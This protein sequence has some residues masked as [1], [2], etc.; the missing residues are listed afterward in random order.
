MNN[1]KTAREYFSDLVSQNRQNMKL[2]DAFDAAKAKFE[3]EKGL[4]APYKDHES[5]KTV[6]NR[7]R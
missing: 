2:S 5:F 1:L 7:K 6:Y 3:R 4:Q